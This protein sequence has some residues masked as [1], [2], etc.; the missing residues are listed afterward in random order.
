MPR[1]CLREAWAKAA[2]A[3]S[4]STAAATTS[5]SALKFAD[6]CCSVRP[7]APAILIANALSPCR[8]FETCLKACGS[9]AA[10]RS[11][12]STS[13][14]RSFDAPCKQDPRPRPAASSTRARS[15]RSSW[16]ADPRAA[17]CAAIAS[18]TNSRS[19]RSSADASRRATPLYFVASRTR[20]RSD[21][22]AALAYCSAAPWLVMS[23]ALTRS[24]SPLTSSGADARTCQSSNAAARHVA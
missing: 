10:T 13:F 23:A 4:A 8:C 2:E 9:A 19:P 7:L 15:D 11:T 3:T 24:R 21:R 12:N 5:G 6:M 14:L 1:S 22:K 18:S 17:P 16:S 20:S